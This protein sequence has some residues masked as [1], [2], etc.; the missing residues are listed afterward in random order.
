MAQALELVQLL[1]RLAGKVDAV[2]AVDAGRNA[3]DALFQRGILT[4]QEAEVGCTFL[5]RGPDGLGKLLGTG[6]A[7]REMVRDDGCLSAS[8]ECDALDHCDLGRFVRG[9]RV[10]RDDRGKAVAADDL[11]VLYEVGTA[12][13]DP[14]RV[15]F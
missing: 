14:L 9:E 11:N 3:L 12:A 4:R 15:L 10:D 8:L 5:R 2:R 7:A 1:A 13:L 6:S